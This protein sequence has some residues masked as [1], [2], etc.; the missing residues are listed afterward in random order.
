MTTP[1][2]D[3]FDIQTMNEDYDAEKYENSKRC[4]V[5][6]NSVRERAYLCT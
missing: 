3:C 2:G 1:L 4:C 5:Q 6:T